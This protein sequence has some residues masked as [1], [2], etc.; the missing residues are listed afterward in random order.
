MNSYVVNLYPT[1]NGSVAAQSLDVDG[2]V[3]SFPTA[4]DN[5]TTACLITSTGGNF[6]VTFDGTTPSANNGHEFV[7][8]YVGWWSKESVR[9]AKFLSTGGSLAHIRMSQFTY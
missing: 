1:P 6:Y 8:P 4:P 2:T 7:A 9:V 3:L 5:K